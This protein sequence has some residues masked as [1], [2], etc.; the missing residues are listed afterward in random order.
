MQKGIV[1]LATI[2]FFILGGLGTAFAAH[3]NPFDPSTYDQITSTEPYYAQNLMIREAWDN[4]SIRSQYERDI[5]NPNFNWKGTP[6]PFGIDLTPNVTSAIHY[7]HIKIGSQIP[8]PYLEGPIGYPTCTQA[9]FN[10]PYPSTAPIH[11]KKC[12]TLDSDNPGKGN[13][14]EPGQ[15]DHGNGNHGDAGNGVGNQDPS[16]FA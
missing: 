6:F 10:A 16:T 7:H 15:T 9:P 1:A 12:T 2:G 3:I 5:T 11:C 13:Q 4:P 8:N 14:G